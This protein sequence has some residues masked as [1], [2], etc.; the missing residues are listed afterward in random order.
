MSFKLRVHIYIA[1]YAITFS[2]KS[3]AKLA[4]VPEHGLEC[5]HK[6]VAHCIRWQEKSDINP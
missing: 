4:S 2:Y 3:L 5:Q 1:Q 6:E